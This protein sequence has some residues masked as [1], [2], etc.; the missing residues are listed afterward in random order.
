MDCKLV[1]VETGLMIGAARETY[2]D[3]ESVLDGLGSLVADLGR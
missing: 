1:D 3:Y 2:S